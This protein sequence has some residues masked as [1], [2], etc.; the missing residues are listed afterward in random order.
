RAGKSAIAAPEIRREYSVVLN[1][2]A[3]DASPELAAQI[4]A[5]PYVKRVEPDSIVHAYANANITI[6]GADK[7]W[8]TSGSRGKGV[9]VAII[10]TGID[11][12]HPALGGGFGPGFKVAGGWD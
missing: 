3:L 12:T 11:Y 1:G 4:R 10:D 6:I 2:V 9:T 5:L 8:T 7:V